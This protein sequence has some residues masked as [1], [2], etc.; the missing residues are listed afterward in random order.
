[1]CG[2]WHRAL[3]LAYVGSYAFGAA[4]TFASEI[5]V[6]SSSPPRMVVSGRV[7]P[8]GTNG[9]VSLLGLA[10]AAVGALLVGASGS[11]AFS[12]QTGLQFDWTVTWTGLAVGVVGSLV[13]SVL[14][15]TLR[16]SGA[17]KGADGHVVAVS[18][19]AK[20]VRSIGGLDVLS[21][22]GVNFVA[23]LVSAALAPVLCCR[24]LG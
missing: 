23:A 19:P 20:G 16:F 12:V 18:R 2:Q 15:A 17:K 10:A 5:G 9:G 13:D 21:N 1:M 3:F 24:V 22:T 6:L 14:G 8:R 7:V 4:D 11:L